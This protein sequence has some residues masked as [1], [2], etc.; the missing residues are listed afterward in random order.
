M[1]AETQPKTAAPPALE[2]LTVGLVGARGYV[3]VELLELIGSHPLLDLAYASSR[4]FEGAAI[5]EHA[6]V[7][8]GGKRFEHLTPEDVV[9]RAADIVILALPVGAA[10]P[11]VEHLESCDAPPRLIVDLSADER[12]DD[13]WTYGLAEHNR[14][15][16]AGATRIS[17]P[18]CYATAAQ[19]ALRPLIPLLAET[20]HCFGVSGYSGAGKKRSDRNDHRALTNGV[21]PYKLVNHTHEREIARHLGAPVRFSPHVAPYFRGITMTVQARLAAPTSPEALTAIFD[22]A[23]AGDLFVEITGETVPRVQDCVGR[24][25]AHIGGF[26]VNPDRPDEIAL[27]CTLDNLR[28]GAASQAIQNINI[29][30]GLSEQMGLTVPCGEDEA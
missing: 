5:A 10:V 22:D 17:N 18:G 15:A 16:I 6:K 21:L 27:V 4:L 29:A 2:T 11:F 24:D 25:G 26:S 23:Y 9:E 19:L 14:D 3:G 28:K 13:A 12:F 1:P 7:S 20:P 30:R 8:F